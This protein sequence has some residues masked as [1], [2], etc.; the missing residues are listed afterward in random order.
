MDTNHRP[1]PRSSAGI[2]SQLHSEANLTIDDHQAARQRIAADAAAAEAR[3]KRL[4]AITRPVL[5]SETD[6]LE[7]PD[8]EELLEAI[9]SA[10]FEE[11]GSRP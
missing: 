4:D 5:I 3:E 10:Q 9:R 8:V 2:T 11:E 6:P 1:G 7:V